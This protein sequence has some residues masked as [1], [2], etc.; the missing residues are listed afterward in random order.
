MSS[1]G[2]FVPPGHFYSPI[3]GLDEIDRYRRHA[4]QPLPDT[5]LAVDLNQ[6]EQTENLRAMIAEY[7]A[8]P[9]FP[10]D[11][12]A[13]LRYYYLNSEFAYQDAIALRYFFRRYRPRRVVE[14]G[15]GYSSACMLDTADAN[16]LPTEFTFVEPYPE[17]LLE[18]MTESDKVRC[19]L[20]V[21][22]L[23]DVDLAVFTR[24]QEHDVLFIDSSHVAK[25]CSDVN[26][27]M[28][29]ILPRLA[30]GVVVHIH[31]INYPF[32]DPAHFVEQGRA[33]TE[34][35]VLRA[36]L[37]YNASFRIIGWNPYYSLMR[38]ELM[39]QM[40]LCVQYGGGSFWMRKL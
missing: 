23:Q 16:A 25:L 29:E 15:C 33:W 9:A 27:Y 28:F 10:A 31:D 18:N 7:Q 21:E 34:A 12:A 22:K 17:R 20:R 5:I 2:L 11:K 19:S 14:V 37:M 30:S 32:T 24:L 3:P 40:P 6:S 1:D 4:L 36:F 39:A 26:W 13:G 38:P 8:L 35:Y